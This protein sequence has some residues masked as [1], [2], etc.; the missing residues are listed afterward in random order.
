ATYSNRNASTLF[1]RSTEEAAETR[2]PAAPA[3]ESPFRGLAVGPA[4]E[5]NLPTTAERS[6]MTSRRT[7][8]P[9]YT[10][11]ASQMRLRILCVAPDQ[12][13]ARA[14]IG[15]QYTLESMPESGW[16]YLSEE[17]IED[18]E[19]AIK[20][21]CQPAAPPGSSADKPLFGTRRSRPNFCDRLAGGRRHAHN[22][23]VEV[24]GRLPGRRPA[25]L[26]GR[27]PRE[28]VRPTEAAERWW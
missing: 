8:R 12:S 4:A 24:F 3:T 28:G 2:W 27:L 18:L 9:G 19:R 6:E 22:F 10:A 17:F 26:R 7:S 21:R 5:S 11:S 23:L 15:A 1:D 20:P 25:R 13:T 14:L 16:T